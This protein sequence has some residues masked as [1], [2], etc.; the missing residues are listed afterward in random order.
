MRYWI[1]ELLSKKI[2]VDKSCI[3]VKY[4]FNKAVLR[5]IDIGGGDDGGGGAVQICV[6]LYPSL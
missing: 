1:Y 3:Y 6:I 5:V 2:H 4:S